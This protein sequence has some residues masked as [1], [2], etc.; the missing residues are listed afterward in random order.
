MH[1]NGRVLGTNGHAQADFLGA[2]SHRDIHDVHDADATHQ[3]RYQSNGDQH[4]GDHARHRRHHLQHFL[5]GAYL[6]VV[7][8]AFRNLVRNTQ[9]AFYLLNRSLS[10]VFG[11]RRTYDLLNIINAQHT[12]LH[13]AVRHHNKVVLVHAHAVLATFLQGADDFERHIAHTDG[14]S[15]GILTVIKEILDDG[16]AYQADLGVFLH[17]FFSEVNAGGNFV[18]PDF[19]IVRRAPIHCPRPV[20]GAVHQLT[21]AVHHGADHSN[22]FGAF[23][24]QLTI[25]DLERLHVART[26][27]HATSPLVGTHH[28]DEVGTHVGEL[29]G[30]ALLQS[31]T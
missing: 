17:I 31:L 5:L 28:H 4:C 10:H 19:Q 8:T 3:Q 20:F 13:G 24:Y 9:D 12:F 2:L 30:R 23:G 22:V 29:V 21:C 16:L 14:L 15:D 6:E 7:S 26:H 27:A 18:F 1:Q 11:S 25:P